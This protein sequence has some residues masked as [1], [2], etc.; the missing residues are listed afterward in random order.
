[1]R[2]ASSIRCDRVAVV[3][4]GYLHPRQAERL[5]QGDDVVQNDIL[6]VSGVVEP[7]LRGPLGHDLDGHLEQLF[8]AHGP[9][10]TVGCGDRSVG[11]VGVAVTVVP[12][13]VTAR[14]NLG[15]EAW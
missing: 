3:I 13:A 12:P 6:P 15:R 8:V 5:V 9:P 1:M 7:A 2:S 11:E 4:K 10:L 14:P